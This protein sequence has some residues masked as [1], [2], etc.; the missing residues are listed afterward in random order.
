LAAKNLEQAIVHFQQALLVYKPAVFAK[1][2]AE[3]HLRLGDVRL[4]RIQ[5][6]RTANIVRAIEHY[7][8]ALE[9]FTRDASAAD[10]LRSPRL[11]QRPASPVD[12]AKATRRISI[13]R[14]HVISASWQTIPTKALRFG[15]S[16]TTIWVTPTQS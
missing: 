4:S 15:S 13:R 12:W 10:Q 11:Q 14:L 1:E 9:V 3:T 8:Q 5:G 2:W 16:P 6:N 7:Q